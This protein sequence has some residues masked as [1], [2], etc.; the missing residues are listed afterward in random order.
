MQLSFTPLLV[1]RALKKLSSETSDCSDDRGDRAL[2]IGRLAHLAEA[3]SPIFFHV[4]KLQA[5]FS[6]DIQFTGNSWEQG[7]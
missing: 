4:R 1:R 3:D 6:W 5:Q 2:K 7:A